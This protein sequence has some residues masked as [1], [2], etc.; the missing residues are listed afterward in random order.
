NDVELLDSIHTERLQKGRFRVKEAPSLWLK[1]NI[2]RKKKQVKIK[3]FFLERGRLIFRSSQL[4]AATYAYKARNVV[5]LDE[6]R[7][8]P[9]GV[10]R[11]SSNFL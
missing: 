10:R 8:I 5:E 9:D 1:Y 4:A 11:R 6:Y 2:S 3:K 7:L